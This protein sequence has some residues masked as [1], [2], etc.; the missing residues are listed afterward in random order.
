MGLVP[1]ARAATQGPD[2]CGIGVSSRKPQQPPRAQT[3]AVHGCKK[4]IYTAIYC[5]M[6]AI[7]LKT[8]E[9]KYLKLDNL[10]KQIAS[11]KSQLG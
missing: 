10:L 1:E 2:R 5:Y 9:I 7:L 6:Y 8:E 4:G 3:C 11:V